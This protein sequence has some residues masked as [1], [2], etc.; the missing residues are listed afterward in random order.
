MLL[1][2]HINNEYFIQELI[3]LTAWKYRLS[4]S[5]ALTSKPTNPNCQFRT[6]WESRSPSHFPQ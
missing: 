4:L 2:E 1:S 3:N 6:F 5:M